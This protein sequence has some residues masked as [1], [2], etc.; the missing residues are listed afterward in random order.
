MNDE[1]E[2]NEVIIIGCGIAGPALAIALKRAGIDSTI[3]EEHSTGYD[4]GLLSLT[5]NSFNALSELGVSEQVLEKGYEINGVNFYSSHGKMMGKIGSTSEM[6]KR[7][8]SGMVMIKRIF[9]NNMLCEKAISQGVK[10]EWGKKLTNIE[11]TKEQKVIAYFEDGSSTQGNVLVGCDGIH[12][13]TRTIMMPNFPKP[14]YTGTALVGGISNESM[15]NPLTPSMYHMTFGKNA[16]FGHLIEKSGEKLWWTYVPYPEELARENKEKSWDEWKI[17]LLE[18]HK[19]DHLLIKQSIESTTET[20]LNLPI[21][22]IEH[23]PTWHN[24]PVCLIGDAAHAISPHAGQGASMAME[25]AIVFAKCLR[26][27]PNKEKAFELFEKIRKERAEKI[28]KLAQQLGNM[29]SMTNPIQKWFRNKII[30]PLFIKRGLKPADWI[31][32]HRIDWDKKIKSR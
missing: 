16:H 4:F 2:K 24:G 14:K 11:I 32:L 13:R 29:F 10:I 6:K 21:Y 17:K 12:S 7:Y 9:L 23:L 25:D 22:N 3:Y 15:E 30:M 31:Y 28:V 8:G 18:L 26:D 5:P 19:D 20:F 1:T 27:I